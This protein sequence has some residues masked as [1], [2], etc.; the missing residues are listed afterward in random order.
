MIRTSHYVFILLI[1]VKKSIRHTHLRRTR[2][3]LTATRAFVGF[4]LFFVFR[5]SASA[6][7][8]RFPLFSFRPSDTLDTERLSRDGQTTPS[9]DS[10]PRRIASFLPPIP[11]NN[12]GCYQIPAGVTSPPNGR[13]SDC[14]N[15]TVRSSGITT[16]ILY[17]ASR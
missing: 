6:L 10:R 2:A 4:P 13:T 17:N 8:T 16:L 1:T 9:S 11:R 5:Y 3:T 12:H 14:E 7:S 15:M